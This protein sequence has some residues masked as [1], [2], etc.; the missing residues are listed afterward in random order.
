MF[1]EKRYGQKNEI[2]FYKYEL[3]KKGRQ[4]KVADEK[5]YEL[6][7][8]V[9]AERKE[10]SEEDIINRLMIPM[11]LETVRCF[12]E[13]IVSSVTDA[14]MALIMGLG[15]PPF[16]GGVF[17]YIDSIGVKAFVELC[18]QYKELGAAYEATDKLR[19]MAETGEK[20]YK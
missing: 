8:E 2:G 17:R 14:D 4:K 7:T 3:D 20:F 1:E 16:R 12:E 11:C 10:F 5:T 6:L 19:D 15:F 13:N 9:T 18:D